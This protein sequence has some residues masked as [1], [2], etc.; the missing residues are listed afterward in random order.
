MQMPRQTSWSSRPTPTRGR[1]ETTS[2]RADGR[3]SARI[4]PS[5][6][7]TPAPRPSTSFESSCDRKCSC[8]RFPAE[9][10]TIQAHQ[11]QMMGRSLTSSSVG[12]RNSSRYRPTGPARIFR[13]VG[14]AAA[15]GASARHAGSDLSRGRSGANPA[16]HRRQGLLHLARSHLTGPIVLG[17]PQAERPI[18][19]APGYNYR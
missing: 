16:R 5:S 19:S 15:E 18:L 13:G 17:R 1:D 12:M 7:R 3:P 11:C 8:R 6:W 14:L 2:R 4:A 10:P 9:D